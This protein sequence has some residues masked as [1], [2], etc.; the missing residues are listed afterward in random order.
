MFFGVGGLVVVFLLILAVAVTERVRGYSTLS[1]ESGRHVSRY[2]AVYVG[3]AVGFGL[4]FAAVAVVFSF[5]DRPDGWK[6]VIASVG[7]L[8]VMSPIIARAF[9]A[10][11]TVSDDGVEVRGLFT[12][13]SI[14]WGEVTEVVNKVKSQK[15]VLSG[16]G[17][18]V[19]VSH[20]FD[21]V[22]HLLAEC[23]R[24]LPEDCVE[25]LDQGVNR[26]PPF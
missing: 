6:A 2:S 13:R 7:L 5:R 20:Q 26:F 23:K 14:G 19:V 3:C 16:H 18:Y 21:G 15:V 22:E 24:R 11:L 17:R 25:N 8:L 10:R 1:S 12:T 9:R 4:M